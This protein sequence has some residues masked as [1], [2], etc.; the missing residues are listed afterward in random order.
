MVRV[1]PEVVDFMHKVMTSCCMMGS[2]GLYA[3]SFVCFHLLFVTLL[4]LYAIYVPT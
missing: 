4:S 2:L 3:L 1:G